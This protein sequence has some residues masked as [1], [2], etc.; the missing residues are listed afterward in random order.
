M[1]KI[2]NSKGLRDE[3]TKGRRDEGTKGTKGTER[4]DLCDGGNA[5]VN[6]WLERAERKSYVAVLQQI[7]QLTIHI[8]KI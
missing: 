7:W 1:R 4:A 6:E 8:W 3:G 5:V 2:E